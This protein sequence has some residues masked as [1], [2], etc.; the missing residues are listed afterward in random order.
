METTGPSIIM[1]V[2]HVADDVYNK[3]INEHLLP[4]DH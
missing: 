2:I 1:V 3:K 4:V